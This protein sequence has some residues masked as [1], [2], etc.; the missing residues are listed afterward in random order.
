MAERRNWPR[1]RSC[2]PLGPRLAL[3]CGGS[4]G[5]PLGWVSPLSINF[6][7]WFDEDGILDS[8]QSRRYTEDVDWIYHEA[9]TILS[10]E[11][12]QERLAV[13]R[14]AG[15]RRKDTVPAWTPVLPSLCDL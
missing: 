1:N 9:A 15:V 4:R 2:H 6:N 12:V 14:V 3:S 5:T 11:E 13:L 10:L 7:L 8:G